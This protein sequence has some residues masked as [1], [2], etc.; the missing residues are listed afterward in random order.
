MTGDD[1]MD[2]PPPPSASMQTTNS[3]AYLYGSG[4]RTVG[5][6][7]VSVQSIASDDANFPD[8]DAQILV[9][10]H[11][12]AIRELFRYF[13]DELGCLMI[14]GKGAALRPCPNT[15]VS[16]F[17]VNVNADN[18]SLASPGGGSTADTTSVHP[19]NVS[20]ICLGLHSKEHLSP[21]PT[22]PPANSEADAA[23]ETDW[24]S[25]R[26]HTPPCD[27][28]DF[29]V[30]DDNDEEDESADSSSGI[31][32]RVRV[33]VRLPNSSSSTSTSSSTIPAAT[34]TLPKGEA[35]L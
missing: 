25:R 6:R 14:G 3:W 31:T 9:V 22:P 11:G 4:V 18:G 19:K 28:S 23:R 10:T 21:W 35:R 20:I 33:R 12:G 17:M 34:S 30:N 2:K 1:A 7:K 29:F 5:A 13:V 27:V 32:A 15:G 26:P 24:F 8:L 16:S